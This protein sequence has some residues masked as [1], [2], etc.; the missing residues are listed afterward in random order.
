M[1]WYSTSKPLFFSP[2]KKQMRN[3][4]KF[5]TRCFFI[6]RNFWCTL[7]NKNYGINCKYLEDSKICTGVCSWVG[8]RWNADLFSGQ[9]DKHSCIICYPYPVSDLFISTIFHAYQNFRIVLQEM[10]KLW[11]WCQ[12][13]IWSLC[14]FC[15]NFYTFCRIFQ[16]FLFIT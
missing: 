16:K 2:W 8:Y 9:S 11:K 1:M 10:T 12:L 15:H 13:I 4:S 6:S 3:I 5:F 14:S 7:L